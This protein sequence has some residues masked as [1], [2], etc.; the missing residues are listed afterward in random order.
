LPP[1]VVRKQ[2][3]S[4]GEYLPHYFADL[5]EVPAMSDFGGEHIARYTTSTHDK[6]AYLTTKPDVIQEMIDHYTAKIDQAADKIALVK[7]DRQDGA[8]TL[9]ISYGIISR[10]ATV[11]VKRARERGTKVSSLVLQTLWPVPEK[12]IKT[13]MNGINKVIVPEMNMGQYRLEIERLAPD[14]VE[15]VGVGKMNTSLVSPAEIERIGGLL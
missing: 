4:N 10:S 13:A 7:Q 15:V 1:L 6:T 9:I 14:G 8:E 11:A 2:A 12:A 5:A 3:R